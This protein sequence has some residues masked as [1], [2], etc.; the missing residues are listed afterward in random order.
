ME[1]FGESEEGKPLFFVRFGSNKKELPTVLVNANIHAGEVEGKEAVQILLRELAMGQHGEL[2]GKLN[3][4]FVPI[5]NVDGN[6]RIHPAHRPDQN[7]PEMGVGTR[8]NAKGLDLN[9]DFIKLESKEDRALVAL[10]MKED[11]EVFMDL[12]ATDGSY[13]GF[14]LTYSPSLSPEVDPQLDAFNR[15]K[16]LPD[17]RKAMRER[18]GF[19][20]FD[21]GNFRGKDPREGWI[22]YDPRPRFGTNYVGLRGRLSILSEAYSH[23]DFEM[24]VKVTKAFVLECLRE[25]AY[26]GEEIKKLCVQADRTASKGGLR[27][28][29]STEL[30]EPVEEEILLG[31]V[32]RLQRPDGKDRIVDLDVHEPMRVPVQ[33]GFRATRF[34]SFPLGWWIVDPSPEVLSVLNGHGILFS[35]LD[36]DRQA[37][38]EVFQPSRIQRGRRT[39]QGHHEL[40]LTGAYTRKG[41]KVPRGSLFVSARQ[42]LSRLAAMLLEPLSED[43]L[44]TWN[45]FDQELQKTRGTQNFP[46]LRILSWV[47]SD[48]RR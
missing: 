26:H 4:I 8:T 15:G 25:V 24:R 11:P 29:Y 10:M 47:K 3:L 46:V 22:T 6:E 40:M 31:R 5:F 45:C 43:S 21:Y 17:V 27:L 35:R 34:L 32:K 33:R 23:L 30:S 1:K 14:H 2:R 9:R 16:F 18:H 7:G 12:H 48:S 41:I 20:V 13:H 44:F 19:F 38:V 36:G 28:G 42:P 37:Q 39:F